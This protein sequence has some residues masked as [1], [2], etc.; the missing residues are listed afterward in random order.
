M[1]KL[2]ILVVLFLSI[3]LI[4]ASILYANNPPASLQK[5]LQQI[6]RQ[7][8]EWI[9][10]GGDQKKI[11]PLA[12]RVDKYL[13]A[14]QF[15]EAE[16]TA[17]QILAIIKTSV[18]VSSTQLRPGPL[19]E[20][21]FQQIQQRMPQWV[22]QGGDQR[23]VGPLGQQ[24]DALMKQGQLKE[25]EAVADQILKIINQKQT[26]SSRPIV[27]QQSIATT[28]EVQYLI[29]MLDAEKIYDAP[30]SFKI[31]D[32][33]VSKI[34]N[35][36]GS[37][38]DGKTRQLGFGL[39][40]PP[41]ILEKGRPGKW[42]IV[43]RQAF[44]VA[45][46]NNLAVYFS[47]E[48]HYFWDTRPDLWNYF[49]PKGPGYNSKNIN[50]VEWISWTKQPHARVRYVDWGTPQRIGAPHMC[51]ASPQIRSEIE[52]LAR[53][54]IVP[55]ILE[56]LEELK[57]EGKEYL[58]AGMTVGSEPGL[59]DFTKIDQINPGISKLLEEDGV[60]K[61]SLGYCSLSY[62][63]YSE[64]NPPKDFKNAMAEANQEF[65]SFWAEN[66]VD[67]GM[68]K[69]KLY[70][71]IA[72]NAENTPIEDFMNAPID[73]AFNDYSRP[74]WTT[75]PWEALRN[76]FDPIYKALKKHG[77]PHWASSEAS[78]F[79][80]GGKSILMHEY[81]SWHYD[82]GAV[83]V[84]MNAGAV[85]G[86]GNSLNESLWSKDAIDAYQKFLN[87]EVPISVESPGE[88]PSSSA[89]VKLGRIPEMA[90]IVYHQNGFI[91]TMD[92]NGKNITQITFENPHP[93]E[94]V[95]VS[96]DHRYVVANEQKPN[97]QGKIG[98]MSI[99]WIY[100][101][102]KGTQ[103][104]LLPQFD[105]AGNGGVDWDKDGFVYFA[106]RKKDE[107][108]NPRVPKD[109]I[110]NAGAN[111][112]Y[113]VK[114]DGSELKRIVNTPDY[115]EA[116]VSVS[117]DGQYLA[118]VAQPL[119]EGS[120]YT[121]IWMANID[122]TNQ[123]RIYKAGNTGI[124]SAHDPELSPDNS[125]VVF[126]IVN[127]KV[128]PNW[129]HNPDANTAHDIWSMDVSGERNTLTRLNQPGPISIIPDWKDDMIVYQDLSE[130]DHYM[131]ASLVHAQG[132]EQ[133]PRRINSGATAP[134]WIPNLRDQ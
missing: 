37:V 62:S 76:G 19:L 94:H 44:Q 118:Y 6:D 79:Q 61:I 103:E 96:F 85:G 3:G 114:P 66:L 21:K 99:L 101:L 8:H 40:I 7:I 15:K 123:R 70:T 116:D 92:R 46:K 77:D 109:F 89:K 63:G 16:Q 122:G 131:G 133:I 2:F 36:I 73:I 132:A 4:F 100:D 64:K 83:V 39:M 119:I 130:K 54:F 32:Q 48:T 113:R 108:K 86:L 117:E 58:F 5:K 28:D 97:S 80:F 124:A 104:R 47:I 110:A 98:G 11:G 111:D 84:V 55:P 115:G 72:A 17:D 30:D 1:K 52:R 9:D 22:T 34:V 107:V 26:V 25:A 75:Y 35:R 59:D 129:P 88:K 81:L 82:H 106:A 90:E 105:M 13:K 23:K 49:D 43:V 121:E 112:I 18:S 24:I 78:P 127:N 68:S 95:A 71:H 33:T 57:E 74:G 10:H 128:K 20:E 69:S 65:I 93:F 27:S 125:Y 134:R 38:G 42:P 51:Y 53:T 45:E 12:D 41:W 91:Y 56:G 50:N 29:F 102:K 120:N 67:A 60:P 31:L 126:S 14:G 87:N